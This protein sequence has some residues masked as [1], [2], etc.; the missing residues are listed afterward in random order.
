MMVK[1]HVAIILAKKIE[2]QL[3]QSE[4]VNNCHKKYVCF[5]YFFIH[6]VLDIIRI[7]NIN[8]NIIIVL[9]GHTLFFFTQLFRIII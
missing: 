3:I 6:V 2:I 4:T 5:N 9:F 1:Y 8:I 7:C